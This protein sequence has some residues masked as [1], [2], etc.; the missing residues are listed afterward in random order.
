MQIL[1]R[2]RTSIVLMA[3]LLLSLHGQAAWPQTPSTIKIIVPSTPGGGSDILARLL[4]DQISRTQGATLVIEN[5]PGA[6]N[7]I[8]TEAA[9]RAAPDGATLMMNTPEFVINP[10]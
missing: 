1:E 5:R 4:A 8:G 6:G 2:S 3:A 10:H 9:A 7:V